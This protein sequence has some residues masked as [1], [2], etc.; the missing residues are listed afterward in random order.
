[1]NKDPNFKVPITTILNILPH[2][3]PDVHSLVIA[4]IYDFDVIISNKSGYKVGERVVYFPVNSILPAKIENFIFPPDSKIKLEKSRVKAV[5]IQKFVSQG[6]IVKWEDIKTLLEL[7]NFKNET[8][9]QEILHVVK[10][11]PPATIVS[12]NSPK[13]K[14][15]RNKP[16]ENPYF[17]E[18]NGC[19]NIKWE[20]YAF[21]ENDSVYITE[22][23][24]GSNWRAG[25]LPLQ[26]RNLWQKIVY[27]IHRFFSGKEKYEFCYGSNTV[28]RQHK[29]DSTTFYSKDVYMQM[30]EKYN[31]EAKLKEHPGIVLYGEIYGPTIQKG[32]HYGLKNTDI[33]LVIFDVMEQ[34]KD[35]QRWFDL[36]SAKNFTEMLGLKFVPVLYEGKWNKDYAVAFA[37]GNSVFCKEQKTIEG[38]VVKNANIVSLNR[39]KIKVINPDYLMK[40]STGETTDATEHDS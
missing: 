4:K 12:N 13:Q 26:P 3:N 31:L 21:E 33:D 10:Y 24:H 18:Y 7:P 19:T 11:Y 2:P 8:D 5:R 37:T 9:M 35:D 23:I 29:R 39:K 17:K 30:V 1:M 20:P 28:Q 27:K 38:V 14:K 40:E 25:Y 34:S 15:P 36:D 32:Y 16:L 6:L 22:K